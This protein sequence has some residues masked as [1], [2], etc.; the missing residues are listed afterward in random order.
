M[1]LKIIPSALSGEVSIPDSKSVSHRALICG[2]LAK[3]ESRITFKN[4]SDD[5]KS[6]V[7]CLRALGMRVEEGR[8]CYIAEKGEPKTKAKL[9]FG[10]SASTA[11][12]LLPIA[13]ALGT[14]AEATGTEG[15]N[16]RPMEPI[17]SALSEHGTDVSDN[18]LPLTIK[19]KPTAGDFYLSGDVSSQFISGL[20]MAA[21]LMKDEVNIILTTPV[22]SVGYIDMTVG[23]MKKFGV[24]VEETNK[25]W[26]IP[27]GSEYRPADVSVEGDWSSAAFFMAGAA[28]GGDIRIKGLDFLSLQGDMAALDVF[29][30]FGANISI[31]DNVLHIRKGTLRSI[32]VNVADIPDMV[33]AIAVTAAFASGKTV[34]RSAERLR[35][36]ES[37]RIK[38]TISM[39][40]A[41]GIK[42]EEFDDGMVIFGGKPNGAVIDG[43]GDHRIVMAATIAAAFAHGESTIKGAEA[44]NKSYPQF[45]EHFKN[46][47]GNV[48]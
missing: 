37:N 27:K 28:I 36:K 38:T 20:M 48:R 46:T 16:K 30:A 41:F 31:E 33:P 15:L 5:V 9:N 8:D 3:G 19:G 44:V 43:A 24:T 23:I 34:I 29:A 25:G 22:Q 6:T 1:D 47:G 26:R 40:N 12:F 42:T 18:K 35:F 45:F 2:A 10:D 32:E 7:E 4:S 11:R 17:I 13:A 14:E 21:P 39:L